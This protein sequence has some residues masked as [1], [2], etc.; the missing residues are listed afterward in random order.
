M[1]VRESSKPRVRHPSCI[2]VHTP[3]CDGSAFFECQKLVVA[4]R[5]GL[6]IKPMGAQHLLALREIIGAVVHRLGHHSFTAVVQ[7]IILDEPIGRRMNLLGVDHAVG[8]GALIVEVGALDAQK[9]QATR[10]HVMRELF[11][12]LLVV[13]IAGDVTHQKWLLVPVDDKVPHTAIRE[14]QVELLLQIE[15]HHVLLGEFDLGIGLQARLGNVKHGLRQ[16]HTSDRHM[17]LA[18]GELFQDETR[19]TTDFQNITHG[20]MVH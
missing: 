15:L 9:Q 7:E 3:R 5:L 4:A 19:A 10:L 2:C 11:Q 14:G 16:V 1:G 6:V 8:D 13:L 17:G 18:L 20:L 12:A